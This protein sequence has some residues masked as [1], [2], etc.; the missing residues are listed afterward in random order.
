M[1]GPAARFVPTL[2]ARPARLRC[3]RSGIRRRHAAPVCANRIKDRSLQKGAKVPLHD[4][5]GSQGNFYLECVERLHIRDP[6][7]RHGRL[8]PLDFRYRVLIHPDGTEAAGIA[9]LYEAWSK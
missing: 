4:L 6:N 9:K 3:A 8:L 2:V 1:A 5:S 7:Q